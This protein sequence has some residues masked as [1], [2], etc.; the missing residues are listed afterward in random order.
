MKKGFIKILKWI[1]IFAAVLVVILTLITLAI[2]TPQVQ[3]FL[4]DKAETWF[5]KNTGAKLQVG[6][7]YL[8]WANE[9][10]V[11]N[12]YLEDA[13]QDTL[14]YIGSLSTSI[15]I[16][17]LTR[18][19][20]DLTA[21]ELSNSTIKLIQNGENQTFN[22][23]FILDSLASGNS[24]PSSSETDTSK[25]T[26]WGI[27]VEEI[28]LENINFSLK[29]NFLNTDLQVRL[30]KVNTEI[31]KINLDSMDFELESFLIDGAKVFYE[32]RSTVLS[33]TD[34][35]EFFVG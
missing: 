8:N 33:E 19:S 32:D 10:E 14:A 17:A 26:S 34:R 28:D 16:V 1:G 21:V 4:T 23:Q 13:N 9:L 12:L 2:R 35:W 20:I 31:D 6:N 15:S 29:N 18:Q 24:Q 5:S 27:S 22:F 3:S 7:I 11:A 30:Q 25:T